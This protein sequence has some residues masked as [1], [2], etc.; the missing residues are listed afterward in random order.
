[1]KTP[2]RLQQ[3][4]SE[5]ASEFPEATIHFKPL[6]SGVCWID[7]WFGRRN[8][9]MEYSPTRGTGISENFDDTPPFIGHDEAFD[10]LDEAAERFKSLLADATRTEAEHLPQAFVLH[11]KKS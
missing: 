5:I 7:V 1:M 3:L 11:D 6:P 2:K 8:F 4:L 9:E 10:S